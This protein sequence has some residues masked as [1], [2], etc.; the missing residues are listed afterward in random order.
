MK[1]CGI[2]KI[3]SISGKIYIGS[4]VDLIKRKSSYKMLSC[5][6][7]IKLYNSLKKHGWEN[8]KF[9]ILEECEFKDLYPLERA[10]GLFYNVLGESGLNCK[11]PGYGEF[12]ALISLETCLKISK[13]RLGSKQ[14][15]ETIKKRADKI[16]GRKHTKETISLMSLKAMGKPKS[17]EAVMKSANSKRGHKQSKEQIA[18]RIKLHTK[19]VVDITTSIIYPSISEAAIKFGYSRKYL[20]AMLN[21]KKPN[22]TNLI[23][24]I[25]AG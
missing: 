3:T 1:N 18:N 14:S 6:S 7:Q 16:R 4:S 12:K 23:F 13:S 5:K 20:G 19:E 2:Y 11:L 21:N 8:H 17:K 25:N 9:E 15:A 22:K 10:W 24:L